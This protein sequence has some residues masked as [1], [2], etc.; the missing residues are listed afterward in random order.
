MPRVLKLLSLA[1]LTAGGISV[2]AC[3][4]VEPPETIPAECRD[5][6]VFELGDPSLTL[7]RRGQVK[8]IERFYA[9]GSQSTTTV[10]AKFLDFG[11]YNGGSQQGIELSVSC[12]GLTGI[13][14]RSDMHCEYTDTACSSNADCAEGV[15]CRETDRLDVAAVRVEGL[16]D[17]AID[18]DQQGVGSFVKAGLTRLFGD[19]QVQILLSAATSDAAFVHNDGRL[20]DIPPPSAPQMSAPALDGSH[21]LQ[22]EDLLLRWTAGADPDSL[23]YFDAIVQQSF[24]TDPSQL[25]NTMVSCVALDDGCLTFPAAAADWLLRPE[26][27]WQNISSVTLISSRR[28]EMQVDLSQDSADTELGATLSSE[29]QGEIAL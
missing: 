24:I 10:G 23:V 22:S 8:L 20:S 15:D 12:V 13:P 26:S 5:D 17:G 14:S 29:Y 25:R 19:E 18:M 2:L 9:D 3:A 1:L 16:L 7:S 4:P 27:G 6:V 11:Q 21:T 28:S